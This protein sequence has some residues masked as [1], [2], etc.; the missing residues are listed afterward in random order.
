M[1]VMSYPP[2]SQVL[3]QNL[4]RGN[5]RFASVARTFSDDIIQNFDRFM[6][7]SMQI[8][9]SKAQS[10]VNKKISSFSE[11]Y[12]SG[13]WVIRAFSYLYLSNW[14]V[15]LAGWAAAGSQP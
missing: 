15:G 3:V 2:R 4:N 10:L 6:S 1:M 7:C 8:G 12:K 5:D 13:G 11:K 9:L 14:L